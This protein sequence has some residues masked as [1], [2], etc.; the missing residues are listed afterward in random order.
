MQDAEKSL[1][2]YRNV[3]K[4]SKSENKL[5]EHELSKLK[6]THQQM[7]QR[8]SCED[9]EKL[10]ISDFCKSPVL[11]SGLGM[12][13][14]FYCI[15]FAIQC[16]SNTYSTFLLLRLFILSYSI[17]SILHW[18]H[19]YDSAR[20]LRMLYDDQLR[21]H[22]I[23]EIW[24]NFIAVHIGHHHRHHSIFRCLHFHNTGGSTRP[25][26]MTQSRDNCR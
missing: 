1:R 12:P 26:G 13:I 15:L 16:S 11:V 2:F 8:A 6:N 22:N 5:F 3:S 21:G 10:S 14:S 25:Q 23:L 7:Q 20:I 17:S 9:K 18:C 4:D 24:I 19:T